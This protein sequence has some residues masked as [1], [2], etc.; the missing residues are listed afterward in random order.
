MRPLTFFTLLPLVYVATTTDIIDA[1]LATFEQL[2]TTNDLLLAAFTSN[3]LEPLG[4]F[5]K[6]FEKAGANLDTPFVKVNCDEEKELC[7]IYDVN[8]YP[9]IRLFKRSEQSG[10]VVKGQEHEQ[11]VEVVRYRGK[12]TKNA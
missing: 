2:T 8:A 10:E 5:H 1:D 6:V 11:G 9:A 3:S 7:K 4:I 12:K